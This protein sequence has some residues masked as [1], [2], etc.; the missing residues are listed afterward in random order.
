MQTF[1]YWRYQGGVK[2]LYQFNSRTDV[3]EFTAEKVYI[4]DLEKVEFLKMEKD[5]KIKFSLKKSASQTYH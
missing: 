4:S 5:V 3:F 2:D 1:Y